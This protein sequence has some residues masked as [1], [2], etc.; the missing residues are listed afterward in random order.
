MNTK[1]TKTL[2]LIAIALTSLV[3]GA[4]SG[5]YYS[6]KRFADQWRL[7]GGDALN[8]QLRGLNALREGRIE[9]ATIRFEAVALMQAGMA[10]SHFNLAEFTRGVTWLLHPA[11]SDTIGSD[12]I[13]AAHHYSDA[14]P[15]GYLKH[16]PRP[17]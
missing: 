13:A 14:H 6:S 12:A 15:D 16:L 3:V 2:W 9:E 4:A 10:Q 5:S 11:P 1:Y 7:R 8:D 17:Q